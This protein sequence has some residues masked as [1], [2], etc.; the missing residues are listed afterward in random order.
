[1]N[2]SR[3]LFR[4]QEI[5][6]ELG[7][8]AGIGLNSLRVFLQYLVYEADPPALLD[9]LAAFL[10]IAARHGH[11]TMFVLFDDCWGPEPA[12]GAQ[13]APRPGVHNSGWTASPGVTRRQPEH[14]PGLERYVKDI[15]GLFAHDERVIAW[16]LYNEP[17]TATRPLVEAAFAWAREVAPSQPLVTC[18]QADDL[19]DLTTVHLYEDPD[20][21]E[22][23]A[24]LKA[25]LLS[26][27]PVL[28]TE[29][30]ARPL[31]STLE[32]ILPIYA[33]AGVGWYVWGL[34]SGATQTRFPW[35]WPAGGPEPYLWFHDLLYPDGTPY[36]QAEV[37]LI[38]SYAGRSSR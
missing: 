10:D 12:L 1:M 14:W 36:R 2:K 29:C 3:V 34:V 16:D 28:C 30:M 20:K 24:E 23:A 8:A 17:Y 21:P 9:R 19:A 4:L 25:A 15:L 18:W 26:G 27:R 38:R 32:R 7:W 37:E 22:V 31:G 5:D 33:A 35:D 6:Q 11:S 13:P